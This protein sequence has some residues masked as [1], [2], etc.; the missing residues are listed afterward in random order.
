MAAGQ[1]EVSAVPERWSEEPAYI[2]RSTDTRRS[3]SLA[4]AS[5]ETHECHFAVSKSES[6][7]KAS[8]LHLRSDEL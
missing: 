6:A 8:L 2:K 4:A 1:A 7:S 3:G 5:P